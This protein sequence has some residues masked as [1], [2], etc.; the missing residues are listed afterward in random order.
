[1]STTGNSI[2]FGDVAV[3]ASQQMGG[4]SPTRGV[5]GAGANPSA[6]NALEFVN[7]ISLGNAVDFGDCT[8]RDE[9][10]GACSNGHG[11]L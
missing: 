8:G 9:C 5:V 2:D 7:I 10:L 11:G 4:S 1:M 3:G 6:T